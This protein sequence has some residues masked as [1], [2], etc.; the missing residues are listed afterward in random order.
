MAKKMS[1]SKEVNYK[2]TRIRES[3]SREELD[4]LA[5]EMKSDDD[6]VNY[7]VDNIANNINRYMITII[8]YEFKYPKK[9]ST[10]ER[11]YGFMKVMDALDFMNDYIDQ[12]KASSKPKEVMRNGYSKRSL[13]KYNKI[14]EQE[15][16]ECNAIAEYTKPTF[17]EIMDN[18]YVNTY[19]G[20]TYNSKDEMLPDEIR[21]DVGVMIPGIIETQ[22]EY[23]AFVQRLKDKG[24]RGL[25]RSIYDKYEDYLEAKDLI[26]TY[27]QAVYD[28]YGGVEEYY[29]ARE[30]GGMFGAYEYLPNIKP[31]FKKTL[32]N[33]KLDKGLNLNELANVKDMGAR[34]RAELDDE[35]EQIE[36]DESY[37][38]Y[39]SAPPKFR[40]L[41]EELHLLYKNDQYGYSGRDLIKQFKKIEQYANELVRSGNEADIAEGYN[42]L[43]ELDRER[44]ASSEIYISTF[45]DILNDENKLCVNDV[46]SQLDYDKQVQTYGVE[47]TD[48]H[49]DI[50]D[51]YKVFKQYMVDYICE[52]EGYNKEDATYKVK[53]QEAED[54]AEYAT[55]YMFSE[56]FRREEDEKKK[57]NSAGDVLYRNSKEIGFSKSEKEREHIRSNESKI[58][59]YVRKL[60]K[61]TQH[62]LEMMTSNADTSE[63]TRSD[64]PSMSIRDITSYNDVI[65]TTLNGFELNPKASELVKY[66]MTNDELSKKIFELSAD[67]DAGDMFSPRVGLDEFVDMASETTKPFMTETMLEE[68]I[69]NKKRG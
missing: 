67:K 10:E 46:I 20:T 56:K 52:M 49:F 59:A 1:N 8:N 26:E 61:A 34:I 41:P 24:K 5:N 36:I 31:R 15:E 33:I 29:N 63:F 48:D 50:R 53:Q 30:L 21:E 45:A 35:I 37:I 19:N 43:A 51:S 57:V 22:E 4:K 55:K 25:G 38:E 6:F 27:V 16:E 60:A 11:S 65:D 18:I 2:I 7:H 12:G 47:Y 13:D 14:V 9:N 32:R 58:Q 66:M 64:V 28:K 3:M 54:M 42:I 69:K 39:E 68:A 17:D 23:F 40:D 44:L 62:S